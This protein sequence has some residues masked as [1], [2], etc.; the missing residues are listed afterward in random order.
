MSQILLKA[1]LSVYFFVVCLVT[2]IHLTIE[3]TQTKN[4]VLQELSEVEAVFRE[5]LITALWGE[6]GAQIEA[7]TNGILRL[8]IV[9][10]SR[11]VDSKRSPP[12]SYS[13]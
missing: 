9:T 11:R 2:I 10:E 3:Y 6:S 4:D 1:I 12:A 8:P 5:S 7:L 13:S